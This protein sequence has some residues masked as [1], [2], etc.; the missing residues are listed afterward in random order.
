MFYYVYLPL[1]ISS[2]FWVFRKDNTC[3]I[4]QAAAGEPPGLG[5]YF[6]IGY[7]PPL[8]CSDNPVDIWAGN[9]SF[10][11]PALSNYT[12][13]D[14]IYPDLPCSALDPVVNVTR[15]C[16]PPLKEVVAEINGANQCAFVCP[17]PSLTS[18]QYDNVKIMQGIL[19]WLSWVGSHLPL[20]PSHLSLDS[21]LRFPPLLGVTLVTNPVPILYLQNSVVL[22]FSSYL[23]Y[24]TLQRATFR[25]T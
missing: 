18:S 6:P 24:L 5:F 14:T 8:N 10:Y 1:L 17:L 3:A 21:V 25:A 16:A 9:S 2:L 12:F 4:A 19:G 20:F 7:F 23:C 13:N 22:R 15:Y 11:R